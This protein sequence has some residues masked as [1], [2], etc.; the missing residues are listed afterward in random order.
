MKFPQIHFHALPNPLTLE[1]CAVK[2]KSVVLA[3]EGDVGED[4][5][6]VGDGEAVV[7]DGNTGLECLAGSG[8]NKCRCGHAG[9]AM[10]NQIKLR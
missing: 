4:A 10:N 5:L 2:N 1:I 8:A 3:G 9:A 6:E 7:G